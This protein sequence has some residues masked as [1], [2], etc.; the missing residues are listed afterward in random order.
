MTSAVEMA[1]FVLLWDVLQRLTLVDN[2]D[3]IR[4]KWTSDG[5][6]TAKSAYRVQLHGTYSTFKSSWVWKAFAEGKH[7]FFTWLLLQHKIL[8]ADKLLIRNW[9]CNE[10]CTF[11]GQELETAPHSL[12][13]LVL[14]SGDLDQSEELDMLLFQC[15]EFR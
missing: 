4:W 9:P 1:E 10:T 12:P 6:Y 8:T 7:K 3:T 5:I 2:P 15:A 13:D 11:C 14:H